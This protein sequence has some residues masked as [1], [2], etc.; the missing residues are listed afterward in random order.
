MCL[1]GVV[2]PTQVE[3]LIPM[4]VKRM[5]KNNNKFSEKYSWVFLKPKLLLVR[6][7]T[8]SSTCVSPSV[9]ECRL[10]VFIFLHV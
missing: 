6:K 10:P 2:T 3:L 8:Y 4:F 7:T 9:S 5:K 1:D